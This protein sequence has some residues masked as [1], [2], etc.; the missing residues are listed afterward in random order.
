MSVVIDDKSKVGILSWFGSKIAS[1]FDPENERMV[2]CKRMKN[3]QDRWRKRKENSAVEGR[4]REPELEGG[5]RSI[6]EE[7]EG[8]GRGD[9]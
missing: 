5:Q 2:L 9:S 8:G 3:T 4:K 1:D 6:I 7:E